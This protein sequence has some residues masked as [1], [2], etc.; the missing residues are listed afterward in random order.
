[1]GQG[2]GNGSVWP[3]VADEAKRQHGDRRP[4][5]LCRLLSGVQLQRRRIGE[6]YRASDLQP[7]DAPEALAVH[8]PDETL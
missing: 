6:L 7:G 5:R 2:V 8:R 3:G 4:R 1:V